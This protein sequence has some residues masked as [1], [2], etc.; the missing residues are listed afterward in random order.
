[1]FDIESCEWLLNDSSD[2]L[3]GWALDDILE[4]EAS[5]GGPKK[6]IY[7]LMHLH[8][9]HLLETFCRKT[10]L[11]KVHM[12]LYC[13]D[14]TELPSVLEARL[15]QSAFDR[16]EVANIA[17]ENYIGLDASLSIFGPLL[18][19]P[20]SNPH[21]TLITLFMNTV[22]QAAQDIVRDIDIIGT[23][24]PMVTQFL[25]FRPSQEPDLN[26]PAVLRS[27]TAIDLVRDYK[28]IWDQYEQRSKFRTT[29]KKT[30]MRAKLK[31]TVV[32]PWPM[33]LYKKPG[34]PGAQEAFN[35]LMESGSMGHEHY[36]EWLRRG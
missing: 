14:A 18:K 32:E 4:S 5:R 17:D 28:K 20:T 12:H 8:V 13:V 9:R 33:R 25:G 19:S 31:N 2:P 26:D 30:R 6:D 16:I 15:K 21:A 35:R 1:M 11:L 34:E 23:Y 29:V 10:A 36:I 27:L 22:H 24:I 3:A 7:G